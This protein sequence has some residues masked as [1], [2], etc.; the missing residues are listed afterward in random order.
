M[1]DKAVGYDWKRSSIYT[2]RH[3]AGPKKLIGLET[4]TQSKSSAKSEKATN[5]TKEK[6]KTK[7]SVKPKAQSKPKPKQKPIEL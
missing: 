2:L 1:S 4:S 5:Q 7:Q 6:A 3:G